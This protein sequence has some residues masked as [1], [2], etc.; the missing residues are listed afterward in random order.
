MEDWYGVTKRQLNEHGGRSLWKHHS[1]IESLLRAAYPDYPWK[2]TLF[3]RL[4][5]GRWQPEYQKESLGNLGQKLGVKEVIVWRCDKD[6]SL[7]LL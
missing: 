1:T 4:A 2:S 5:G 6:Y 3:A 7:I